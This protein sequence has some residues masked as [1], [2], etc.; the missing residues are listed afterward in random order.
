MSRRKAA[1]KQT[2]FVEPSND[3]ILSEAANNRQHIDIAQDGTSLAKSISGQVVEEREHVT[4]KERVNNKPKST[5]YRNINKTAAQSEDVIANAQLQLNEATRTVSDRNKGKEREVLDKD[6]LESFNL[7]ANMPEL[8][9]APSTIGKSVNPF[10][11]PP[12]ERVTRIHE[13]HEHPQITQNND[14]AHNI[15]EEEEDG[16]DIT[17][18]DSELESEDDDNEKEENIPEEPPAKKQKVVLET[19]KDNNIEEE[20]EPLA[21]PKR[22]R[23]VTMNDVMRLGVFKIV[24]SVESHTSYVSGVTKKLS[25]DELWNECFDLC[26]EKWNKQTLKHISP[27]A[28]LLTA[29]VFVFADVAANNKAGVVLPPSPI[30][31]LENYVLKRKRNLEKRLKKK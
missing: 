30:P 4:P 26:L 15:E 27:E 22:T 12:Q 18:S 29:S 1:K 28:C 17:Y 24:H 25:D 11:P 7:L 19:D 10:E 9:M 3:L 8:Q 13:I 5:R 6:I 31:S 16:E 14:N 20:E 23:K 2:V 21:M